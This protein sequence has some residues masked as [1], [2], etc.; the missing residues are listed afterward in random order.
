MR[1]VLGTIFLTIIIAVYIASFLVAKLP[2]LEVKMYIVV[3]VREDERRVLEDYLALLGRKIVFLPEKM[4][5]NELNKKF[6]NRFK[7]INVDREFTREGVLINLSF[8]RR[9]P[10]AIVKVGEGVYLIDKEGVV[11]IDSIPPNLPIIRVKDLNELKSV[12]NKV[13]RI[14]TLAD[15][16]AILPDKVIVQKNKTKYILPKIEL[17]GERELKVLEYVI[18]QNFDANTIDLRYKNFILLR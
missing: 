3:G 2:F 14:A 16:V 12:G 7:Y 5:F 17:I 10:V 4:I 8:E 15:D 13:L 1:G 9:K 18:H 6:G 11:F